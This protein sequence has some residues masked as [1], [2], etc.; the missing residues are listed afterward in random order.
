M[1]KEISVFSGMN[2]IGISYTNDNVGVSIDTYY[3]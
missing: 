3:I 2:S 1:S